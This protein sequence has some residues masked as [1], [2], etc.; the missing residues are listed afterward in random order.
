VGGKG[1]SVQDAVVL[2]AGA[3]T[4]MGRPKALLEV[5][6]VP[7]LLHHVRT[8]STIGLRVHVVLGAYE[9]TLRT[10]LPDF[11]TV[12]HNP[13]WGTTGPAE[14]AFVAL[15][16]LG[17]A[18]VTPVDVPPARLPDL[19]RLLDAG[20]PALLRHRGVDGHPIRLDPP[21][22]QL[23]LDERLR[24]ALRIETDDPDVVR[25]LNTPE[26]WNAW[27]AALGPPDSAHS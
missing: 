9:A 15:Q 5:G 8:F 6:G 24:G 16:R 25:N 27:L 23:R 10:V 3:S 12:H 1:S 7:L 21:H 11:V 20:G 19:Q 2:A 17:P 18:L 14:S 22:P 26:E 13:A 4:R